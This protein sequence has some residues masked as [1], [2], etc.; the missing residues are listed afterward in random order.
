MGNGGKTIR[1]IGVIRRLSRGIRRG[2][3]RPSKYTVAMVRLWWMCHC[4]INITYLL[5]RGR[6]SGVGPAQRDHIAK[7]GQ[8]VVKVS[9]AFK[10]SVASILPTRPSLAIIPATE[11]APSFSPPPGEVVCNYLSNYPPLV[12]KMASIYMWPPGGSG[13]WR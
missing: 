1:F 6:R 5:L 2:I 7:R 9:S 8:E 3:S 11:P 10:S 13:S 12:P 4:S